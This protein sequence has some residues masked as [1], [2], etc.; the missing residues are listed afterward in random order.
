MKKALPRRR[1]REGTQTH[2]LGGA[3]VLP[4]PERLPVVLGQPP[5]PFDPPPL[6]PLPPLLPPPPPV[7]PLPPPPPPLEPLLILRYLRA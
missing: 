6:L 3:F 4:P 2:L 5:G 1:P 7:E